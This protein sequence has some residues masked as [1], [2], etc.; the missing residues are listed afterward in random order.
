VVQVNDTEPKGRK[1][2]NYSAPVI[3]PLLLGWQDT[4]SENGAHSTRK[5]ELVL[6]HAKG[7]NQADSCKKFHC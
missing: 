5:V 2:W 1:F 3:P 6:I 7:L 4:A